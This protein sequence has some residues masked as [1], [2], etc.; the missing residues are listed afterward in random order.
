MFLCL[1]ILAASPCLFLC[2]KRSC[3]I[4]QLWPYVVCVLWGLVVQPPQSPEW[5]APGAPYPCRLCTLFCCSWALTAVGM[6]MGRIDPQAIKTFLE[7]TD[8]W[9]ADLSKWR[10]D[11]TLTY[12]YQGLDGS[13]PAECFIEGILSVYLLTYLIQGWLREFLLDCLPIKYYWFAL[14][15][16]VYISPHLLQP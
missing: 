5:G 11:Q 15:S 8:F 16:P 1:L 10:A 13:W 6:S 2:I 3:C 9:W 12:W 7:S 14:W 4:S